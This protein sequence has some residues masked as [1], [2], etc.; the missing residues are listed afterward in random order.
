MG[1]LLELLVIGLVVWAV[2]TQRRDAGTP[3]HTGPSLRRSLQYLGL[4]ASLVAAATGVSELVAAALTGGTIAGDLSDQVALGLALTLV[5][6]PVWFLLWRTVAATLRR[7]AT[8]RA[9]GGWGLY[10]VAAT[11]GSL[12]VWL[13]NLVRLAEGLLDV[14]PFTPVAPASALVGLTVWLSH[15]R[16]QRHPEL[17]PTSGLPALG[18]LAGATVGLVALTIGASSVLGD[19]LGSLYDLLFGTVLAG[20][21]TGELRTG[22][23]LTALAVGIWW[24]H[25]WADALHAER[26]GL[27]HGYVLLVATLGGLVT[28]LAA[29][30]TVLGITLQWL[31]GDPRTNQAVVHFVDVPGPAAASV[32]GLAVWRYHRAVRDATP[33]PRDE[34]ARVHD[35][36][37][38]VL[39][40]AAAAGGA[41]TVVAAVVQLLVPGA[42]V[43]GGAARNALSVGL[44]LLVV[45]VPLW[46]AHWSRLQRLVATDGADERGSAS[47]R[48]YVLLLLGTTGLTTV[49]SLSV[50]LYVTFR[51]LLDGTLRLTVLHDLRIAIGLVLTGGVLAAYHWQVHR[52]DRR[53]AAA[54]A[55]A[56]VH[57]RNVLLVS[58]DDGVLDAAVAR[59]TGA[60]VR[61]LHRLDTATVGFDPDSVAAAILAD[62]HDS[63]LVT[64]EGDGEIRVIPYEPA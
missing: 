58:P 54:A 24:W 47:R 33:G 17:G 5:A 27:W 13:V 9:S 2:R 52:G 30:G 44:T 41:T 61:G 37:A 38:A 6:G 51:D 20:G 3:G 46:W 64:L 15:L 35:H 4:L 31:V 16:L 7:E 43:P 32:V 45:G 34:L 1:L 14:E 48:A 19:A 42:L 50:A 22:L 62:G 49:A 29:A 57:P 12:V 40:L 21:G 53:H 36:V 18:V 11:T 56:H 55:P 25:W 26:D 28:A 63:V 10:L 60:R 59:A 39:G 8:E 23:V